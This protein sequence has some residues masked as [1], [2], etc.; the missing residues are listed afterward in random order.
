MDRAAGFSR[1][2]GIRNDLFHSLLAHGFDD[3]RRDMGMKRGV[4]LS[5]K[6]FALFIRLAGFAQHSRLLFAVFFSENRGEITDRF[7]FY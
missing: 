4:G 7:H 1:Q 2:L 6:V 5:R 3:M